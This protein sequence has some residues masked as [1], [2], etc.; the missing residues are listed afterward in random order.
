MG[1]QNT[2]AA[3][4]MGALLSSIGGWIGQPL[5]AALIGGSVVGIIMA[6]GAMAQ[7]IHPKPK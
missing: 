3:I 4:A 1:D 2:M 7:A 6:A 5:W